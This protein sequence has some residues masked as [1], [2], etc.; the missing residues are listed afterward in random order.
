MGIIKR[1]NIHE[2][3]EVTIPP[4]ILKIGPE[5]R[6]LSV[7]FEEETAA[8]THLAPEENAFPE[9]ESATGT[10]LSERGRQ[11]LSAVSSLDEV[12]TEAAQ[13]VAE[14]RKKAAA[15]KKAAEE[16]GREAGLREGK[17]EVAGRME[18]A[19]GALNQAVKQRKKIIKD[20]EHEI[21]RLSIK[22]AEQIIRSEV[23]L[24]RDVCLNIVAEAIGRVSDRE[25]IILKV[26]REDLEQVKRYKDR[27][28]G[29]ID[30]VKNFSILEDPAV[31]T[32]GCVI[33]T[34]LGYVDARIATKL[35]VMQDAL[36]KVAELGKN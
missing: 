9:S 8:P 28:A 11:I 7:P 1:Q 21:L 2:S 27:I 25:Q 3:G 26:S 19:L 14:S 18:E 22:V 32:G 24:H 29:L 6:L 23:S 36:F 30:G 17:K 34:N 35:S 31:E 13:I 4:G 16:E 20:A 12:K 33:E 10:A 15:F 5:E